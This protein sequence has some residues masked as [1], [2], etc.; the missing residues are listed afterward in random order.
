MADPGS[1]N[2]VVDARPAAIHLDLSKTAVIVVDMQNDFGAPGGMFDRAGI[3][4]TPIRRIVAPTVRVLAAAREADLPVV[5]LKQEHRPDLSDAG[6]EG[7]PHRIKHAPL[8]LGKVVSAPDGSESRILVKDT[9]NTAIVPELTPCDADVVISKHRYSG[10]FETTLDA[11]L[12]DLGVTYLVFAGA[13]TSVCVESTVRDAMYRDYRCVVLED[14][15]AEPIGLELA[16]SNHEASLLT[17]E[18][19]FGWVASSERFVTAL[20]DYATR[21]S[22]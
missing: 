20:S 6:D 9:W 14:C 11:R 22:T 19:L 10:F 4:I 1:E 18:L 15:T 12:R 3:D 17:I 7:S 16:R 13:T 2:V 8:L 5:Y 21:A